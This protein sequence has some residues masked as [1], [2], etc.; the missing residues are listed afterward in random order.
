V[1]TKCS[2]FWREIREGLGRGCVIAELN[3]IPEGGNFQ[4][5]LSERESVLAGNLLLIVFFVFIII[6][7][8]VRLYLSKK[9]W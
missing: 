7:F 4:T 2:E 3:K 5:W 9:P 6:F 8:C 1:K